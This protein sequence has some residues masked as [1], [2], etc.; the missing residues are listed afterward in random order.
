MSNLIGVYGGSFDPVHNAHLFIAEH[1]RRIYGFK[2][3]IWVPT[4]KNPD[5]KHNPTYPYERRCHMVR[6]VLPNP[7]EHIVFESKAIYSVDVIKDLRKKSVGGSD[8]SYCLIL[9]TDLQ[10]QYPDW[11]GID[12]LRK[13]ITYIIW[14]SRPG[15]SKGNID[16]P[17]IISSTDIKD[18]LQ[19]HNPVHGLVHP[20]VERQLTTK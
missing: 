10:D 18:R 6:L 19:Q 3:L 8:A 15:Y 17:L 4:P 9:G 14:V 20:A 13:L 16:C 5:K 11:E 12:E 2:K 1:A 7:I